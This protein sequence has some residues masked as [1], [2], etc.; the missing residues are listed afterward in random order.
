M[1][2]EYR[3]AGTDDLDI[4]QMKEAKAGKAHVLL[5]RLEDGYRAFSPSCPHKGAPLSEGYLH[6]EHIRCPWHQAVFD[7]KT[8]ELMEPCSLDSISSF[9]VR[10]D[11]KDLYVTVPDELPESEIPTMTEPDLEA[12]GRVFA[13]VGTGASGMSAA[14]TLR[15]DGFKGRIVMVTRE[16]DLPYDRTDLSKSYLSDPEADEP[17]VRSEAFYSKFGIEI[18]LNHEV[19]ELDTGTHE[20]K[21]SNGET[22]VFDRCLLATGSTP[23]CLGVPGE[24][25]ANIYTLRSYEDCRRIRSSIEKGSRAVVIGASFIGMEVAASLTTRGV[26]VTVVAP[27]DVPFEST[28]GAVVGAM[29]RDVHEEKGVTF[30]LGRRVR[31]FEGDGKVQKVVL[32]DGSRLDADMVIVGIGVKPNTD[33][34]EG[35]VPNPDGSLDVDRYMRVCEDVYAA[36]DIARFPDWRG[37]SMIRIEHWRLALQLGRLAAHN[38]AGA[39]FE[40]RDVPFFWTIQYGVNTKYVGYAEEWDEFILDGSTEERDFLGYYVKDGEVRA[41][42]GCSRTLSLCMIAEALKEGNEI[43]PDDLSQIIAR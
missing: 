27:E 2:N 38:M 30:L 17:S 7:G 19:R 33:Y 12:D 11:G 8:G 25:L 43:G 9:E 42:A 26:S 1:P 20:I 14:E 32:D 23:R 4:G 24:N 13:I 5:V 22:L 36:G 3:I 18:L 41:A 21:F 37:G 15:Q 40:Y 16:K 28:L 29:Y 35:V 6:K 34:L 39:M 10:A 31:E